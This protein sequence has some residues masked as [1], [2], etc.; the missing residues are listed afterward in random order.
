LV[1][2]GVPWLLNAVIVLPLIGEGFA[3]ARHLDAAGMVGFAA[4]HTVFFV[5]L[6]V[7]YGQMWRE[8]G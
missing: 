1:Y 8:R 5:L 3:G 4:A 7:L 2:A 6:A